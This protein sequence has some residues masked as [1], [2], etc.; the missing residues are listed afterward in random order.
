MDQPSTVTVN[1]EVE[2]D[3]PPELQEVTAGGS[4]EGIAAVPTTASSHL[5]PA[6][7]AIES[8]GR[9]HG[10]L[11]AEI[12]DSCHHDSVPDSMSIATGTKEP[13][14]VDNQLDHG[15]PEAVQTTEDKETGVAGS[16]NEP[17]I[18]FFT[19]LLKLPNAEAAT[20]TE[21]TQPLILLSPLRSPPA[22]SPTER[23]QESLVKLDTRTSGLGQVIRKKKTKATPPPEIIVKKTKSSDGAEPALEI[24]LT[25]V[26]SEKENLK[27]PKR[28]NVQPSEQSLKRSKITQEN[29]KS[30]K[31]KT[32]VSVL[33]STNSGGF[34][35]PLRPQ[36]NQFR[37]GTHHRT[38]RPSV[39]SRCFSDD[40]DQF[41]DHRRFDR[42][43]HTDELYRRNSVH[44][45][46]EPER[47]P[48]FR[49]DRMRE[50][51]AEEM[52]WLD[53]MPH[54]WRY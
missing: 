50:L 54:A 16:G 4:S 27:P 10:Q 5:H 40:R 23:K 51:S 25:G 36:E 20:L 28:C 8:D 32:M 53:R 7:D 9:D 38:D 17:E 46:Y 1:S 29:E 21:L 3:D 18:T 14:S 31:P 6:T 49:H 37:S 24:D 12:N 2:P 13:Q 52:R 44:R 26:N 35:I 48:D 15:Q 19:D 43:R 41:Q 34:K 42:D 39:M 22:P 30:P 33:K 47:N 11:A 45:R